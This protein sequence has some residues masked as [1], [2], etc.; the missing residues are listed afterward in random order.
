MTEPIEYLFEASS[1]EE[2]LQIT[3][4]TPDIEYIVNFIIIV[5]ERNGTF[6]TFAFPN[7]EFWLESRQL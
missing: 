3:G 6:E 1:D 7:S 4:T 2:K 5:E